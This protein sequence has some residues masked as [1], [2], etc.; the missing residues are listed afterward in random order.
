MLAT[1]EFKGKCNICEKEGHKASA[2]PKKKSVKC[3]HCGK[4]GHRKEFCWTLPENK[5]KKPEWLKFESAKVSVEEGNDV[6]L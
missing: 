3:K 5:N 1:V 4:P 2:C 6:I